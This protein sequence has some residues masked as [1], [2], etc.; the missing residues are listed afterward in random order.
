M[1]GTD[2][3]ST[4]DA[5]AQAELVRTG[6]ATPLELVD[7]A[8]ARVEKVNPEINAVIHER[9]D[10]ARA[11]AAGTLPDGPFRGV[12]FLV[13]DL[14]LSMKGEPH[15]RGSR[16]LKRA[17]YRADHDSYLARRFLAAGLVVVGRTNT[18]EFGSTVTTEPLAYGPCRNPWNTDHSTGGS[19]GGSAAAV[20]A[21]LVPVAHAND[22]GGS[23]R[24]PASEC[25][26]VGLKPSRG[27]VTH[28]PD[29]GE[30]WMGATID[31]VVTRSVRDTAA[32]LDCIAGYEPGDPY[33][34]PPPSRRYGEEVGA[35]PGSLRIG[36][37]DH[38]LAPGVAGHPDCAAAVATAARLLESLGHRVEVG[39]P[40]ALEEAEVIPRFVTIVAASTAWALAFWEAEL[41][42]A[43]TDADIEHDNLTFRAIGD[44]TSA[45]TYLDAVN[46]LHA[47]SRR[48]QS[49]WYRDGFDILVTPTLAVPPPALGYL[50][51]PELGGQRV[52]EVLQYTAQFNV[53]GQPAVSLP[54]HWTGGGLPVGVQLVAPYARE[55]VLIR[56]ASQLETA[57]PWA[58]RL[59]PVHA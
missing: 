5:T 40:H 3:L 37:L 47:W 10:K 29:L 46:W 54:L 4:M 41:G 21:G 35:D 17:G 58:E 16:F 18:P 36:V 51:D 28:G 22:G 43:A 11:E 30:S 50:S 42:R 59:P 52:I 15:H 1:T 24:V 6:R 26:L 23:I 32:M 20:A 14:E 19:S 49:W 48:V 34:A 13:K 56:L 39:H 9:F 31:G 45:P 57:Q 25:A 2:D 53:T 55:E 38:P 7:A 44:A 33:T 12:P 8:I 27:R